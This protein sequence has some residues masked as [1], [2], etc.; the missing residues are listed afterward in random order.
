[1][2][3]FIIGS[4]SFIASRFINRYKSE[5]EITSVS[6]IPINDVSAR[7]IPDLFRIPEELFKGKSTVINF[8]AIVH[9]PEIRDELT[10]NKINYQLALHNANKAKNA[11]AKLFIQMSSIAVY[12]N[13]TNISAD[14]KTNPQTPYGKSKLRA[15]EELFK[16]Q[17]E[18]FKI[19]SIR[20]PMVYGGG[21]APGNMMRLIRL[22]DIGIPL[23]YKGIN[24]RRDFIN[25]NNLIQYI[26]L[27]SDNKLDGIH[28]ISDNETVSTALLIE[29]IAGFLNKKAR[30]IKLPSFILNAIKLFFRIEY[31]KSFE[32][33][34]ISPNSD[35]S[36][37]IQRYPVAQGIKEMVDFYKKQRS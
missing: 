16:I 22:V 29:I 14:T 27:F 26:K 31:N 34:T 11:G 30:L 9:H 37:L 36:G 13:V 5:T 2:S 20:A 6:R 7:I 23:P 18:H 17:D 8:V 15:D 32:T 24:N 19:A 1:M 28:L 25:V 10:I 33:L 12:G 35:I 21:G 3:I 4:D